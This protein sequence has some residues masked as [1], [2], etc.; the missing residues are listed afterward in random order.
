MQSGVAAGVLVYFVAVCFYGA[1]EF[2]PSG[3][4]HAA[5]R[6]AAQVHHP[7]KLL[8]LVGG[9]R[10]GMSCGLDGCQCPAWLPSHSLGGFTS[11]GR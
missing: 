1:G 5:P 3:L 10:A 11:N 4:A 9:R 2:G 7:M 8:C 6:E